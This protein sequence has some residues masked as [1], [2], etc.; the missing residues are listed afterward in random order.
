MMQG[1]RNIVKKI[2]FSKLKWTP[3]LS[4][5]EYKTILKNCSFLIGNSSSGIH[6]AATYKKQ[7]LILALD[8]IKDCNQK[9]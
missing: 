5:S 4:L 8:R 6:E 3:T 2:K 1:Y 9:I 7:S